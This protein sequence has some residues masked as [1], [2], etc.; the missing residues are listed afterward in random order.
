M[1]RGDFV[2][3]TKLDSLNDISKNN[4]YTQTTLPDEFWWCE[5]FLDSDIKVGE[6]LFLTRIA[7]Y[8]YPNGRL[9]NF[10]TT[11][12]VKIDNNKIYTQN[13]I[14][15]VDKKEYNRNKYTNFNITDELTSSEK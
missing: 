5:G 10:L 7:N 9:G 2:K 14:Y 13:S 11:I 12:F 3:I 6:K 4:Y 8:N 1:K 15:Q